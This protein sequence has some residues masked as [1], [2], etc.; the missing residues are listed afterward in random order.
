MILKIKLSVKDLFRFSM[1]HSY[2]GQGFL[3]PFVFWLE[4]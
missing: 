2:Q 3:L 4:L 1:I